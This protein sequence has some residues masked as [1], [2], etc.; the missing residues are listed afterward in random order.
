MR[1]PP[2]SPS[3]TKSRFNTTAQDEESETITL[4][5]GSSP[6]VVEE[7]KDLVI[8]E[9][10]EVAVP[11]PQPQQVVLPPAPPKTPRRQSLHRAV[12]IRSAHRAVLAANA[13]P[14]PTTNFMQGSSLAP[15]TDNASPSKPVAPVSPTKGKYGAPAEDDE[16]DS[17]HTDT[18]DEEEEVRALGLE[19]VSVSSGSESEEDEED[20]PQPPRQT[21]SWR[22]SL[23]RLWPFG[24][25]K[26]EEEEATLPPAPAQDDHDH[27]EEED[28]DDDDERNE[29][30]TPVV[31]PKR[32]TIITPTQR[33]PTKTP[34]LAQPPSRPT[35]PFGTRRSP[36]KPTNAGNSTPFGA[37][38]P[39]K[40]TPQSMSPQKN[41]SIHN[42]AVPHP[43]A[44]TPKGFGRR[45]LSPVVDKALEKEEPMEVDSEP[46]SLYAGLAEEARST[47]Q[48]TVTPPPTTSTTPTT[49]DKHP[50]LN[51]ANF[52]TPQ[53][54]RTGANAFRI[55]K[56]P[57]PNAAP[58]GVSL[59][60]P[61]RHSVAGGAQRIRIE[62]SP[63][64][65]PSKSTQSV[66]P[67][68]ATP[69]A[70]R[71]RVSEAE[72]KAI[73]ERRKSALTAPDM[74]WA[75]GAPGLSPRKSPVKKIEKLDDV[76]EEGLKE[77]KDATRM[78]RE[79]MDTVDVLKRRRES[80]MADAADRK[81]LGG[82][83]VIGP[84]LFASGTRS[85]TPAVTTN[86]DDDDDMD[87]D[88]PPPTAHNE[89]SRPSPSFSPLK[90][91]ETAELEGT[92]P[93]SRRGRSKAAA[94]PE[95]E[96]GPDEATP[97]PEIAPITTTKTRRGRSA[98]KEPESEPV[99]TR[100]GRSAVATTVG[101]DNEDDAP[102][103]TTRKP[104]KPPSV[105]TSQPSFAPV[106]EPVAARRGRAASAAPASA[107]ERKTKTRARS[108]A[109]A[110]EEDEEMQEDAE[111][112]VV[113]V[114][115]PTAKRVGRTAAAAKKV[116]E[117]ESDPVLGATKAA[118]KT[119][120]RTTRKGAAA[121]SALAAV[122]KEN[123]S[124]S[125]EVVETAKV[126]LSRSRKAK[127]GV[128]EVVVEVEQP[129]A[130]GAARRTRTRTKT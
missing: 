57:N 98:S 43:A 106:S 102:V 73:S 12:L 130:T 1:A 114:V 80:I 103:A 47:Q 23:E 35:T 25:V 38:S 20:E 62:D 125:E 24:R 3:P 45:G 82:G 124:A 15:R 28:N 100:R 105:N 22:K 94:E 29:L 9:D 6:R 30:Q 71:P 46:D 112:E 60:L 52:M 83:G 99:K 104:R 42:F 4:V 41:N 122:E 7:E 115:A 13:N 8:L 126:R 68:A 128:S 78:L 127:E 11:S 48:R 116:K 40:T 55:S 75:A 87:V 95:L 90:Q 72:R 31:S 81:S 64:K 113:K 17:D 19:V 66:V 27:D 86:D 56:T 77:D 79:M 76:D 121:A 74:F 88:V 39:V 33:S 44:R 118:K 61:A 53:A 37:R 123:A 59:Q 18:E 117:E 14:I 50:K 34:T 97:L 26:D 107:P 51:L 58:G 92:K 101:Q 85:L 65:K 63:W 108:R 36:D 111:I 49:I 2:R 120:A 10:V 32:K 91:K 54:P 119:P 109:A 16:T 110:D 5:Q 21:L 84:L 129:V 93:P 67:A 69:V 70:S 96:A 89:E